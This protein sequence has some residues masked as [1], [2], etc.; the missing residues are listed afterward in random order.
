MSSHLAHLVSALRAGFIR[1]STPQLPADFRAD[2]ASTWLSEATL[3]GISVL[4]ARSK[5]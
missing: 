4:P 3:L 2:I 5:K 1:A